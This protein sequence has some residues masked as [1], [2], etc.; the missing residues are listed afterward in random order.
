MSRLFGSRVYLTGPMDRVPDGGEGWRAKIKPQLQQLGIKVI[1]PCDKPVNYSIEDKKLREYV[2]KLKTE[3]KFDEIKSIYKQ[4]RATDLRFVDVCDFII[5][6]IK[7]DLHLCGSYEELFLANRQKKP[8]LLFGEKKENYPNWLF[9]TIPHQFFF[10]TMDELV[11][12]LKNLN[13]SVTFESRGR[14]LFLDHSK[15]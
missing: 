15:L 10:E 13:V 12:Y 1:D 2:H 9:G 5:T 7:L 6:Y 4:I 3:H 14:W 8:I 11:D